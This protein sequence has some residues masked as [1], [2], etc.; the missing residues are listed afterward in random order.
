MPTIDENLKTWSNYDWSK[1]GDEWSDNWGGTEYMW[2]LTIYPRIQTFL[3]AKRILEIAP[4]YGRITQYLHKFCKKLIVVDLTEKCIIA[5]KNRFKNVSNI[6]YF[7]NDGISLDMIPD[8]SIDFV[9]SWDSL[10]HA[11]KDVFQAYLKEISKKLTPDGVGF[12]HHSN[13][14]VYTDATTG[15]LTVE[16]K[17]W[18]ASNMSAKLFEKYCEEVG[19]QCISQEIINWGDIILNDCFSL[20]TRKSS[21]YAIPNRVI[22]NKDFKNE[23][24]HSIYI[25][26]IYKIN[27]RPS[28]ELME[29]TLVPRMLRKLRV[30]LR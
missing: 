17:H 18:R 10:V 14:A 4:G 19:L 25:S 1:G 16:N 8:N 12:I 9:F 22:E 24:N 11:E 6:K 26:K 29:N 23:I 20:F 2:A 13:L 5:C 27:P 28:D 30:N 3:P 15:S 7:V 21:R